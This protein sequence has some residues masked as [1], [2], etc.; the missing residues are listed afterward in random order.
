VNGPPALV[1][2]DWRQLRHWKIRESALPLGT[3]ISYRELTPWERYAKYG[4]AVLLLILLQ[5]MLIIWLTV[6]TSS[7]PKDGSP[8]S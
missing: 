8:S 4:G 7:E 2:V 1:H 6:A 5:V 3:L